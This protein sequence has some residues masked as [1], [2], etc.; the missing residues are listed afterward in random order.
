MAHRGR[1]Y[2]VAFR[3]DFNFQCNVQSTTAFP[4]VWDVVLHSGVAPGYI[5]DG[6]RFICQE[7]IGPNP[8]TITWLSPARTIGIW[9]WQ[10]RVNL[11]FWA[12]P[13]SDLQS[14]WILQRDAIDVSRWRRIHSD[15]FNPIGFP[16]G[17]YSEVLFTDTTTFDR[18]ADFNHSLTNPQGY[19]P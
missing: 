10:L 15:R 5:V 19:P 6:E 7:I 12:L 17:L 11:S 13:D 2:P 4:K 9:F 1:L 14:T 18:G 8:A 16:I 3:R